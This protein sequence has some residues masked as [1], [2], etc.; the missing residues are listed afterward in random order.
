M[1]LDSARLLVVGAGLMGAG[2]AYTCAKLGVDVV[3][4]PR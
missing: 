4:E 2:I 1:N 3:L